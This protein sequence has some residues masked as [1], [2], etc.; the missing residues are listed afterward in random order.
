MCLLFVESDDFDVQDTENMHCAKSR[1]AQDDRICSYSYEYDWNIAIMI[2]MLLNYNIHVHVPG[3]KPNIRSSH[4]YF[5][6]DRQ[7]NRQKYLVILHVVS[8]ITK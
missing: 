6:K 1:D 7:P 2:I 8:D 3:T 5:I 4:K